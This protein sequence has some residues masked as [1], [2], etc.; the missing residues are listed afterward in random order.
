MRVGRRRA[1]FREPGGSVR[2]EDVDDEDEGVGALDADARLTLGSVALAGWDHEQHLGADGLADEALVPTRDHRALPD[3]EVDRLAAG[4]RRVEL[5]A[6][7]PDHAGVVDGD[8]LAGGDGGPRAL[9][10]RLDDELGR[11][12][13]LRDLDRG[14]AVGG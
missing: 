12:R 3:R 13:L 7:A 9:D 10:E 2:V 5:L 4:P 6:V 11:C 8:R 14:T 1:S